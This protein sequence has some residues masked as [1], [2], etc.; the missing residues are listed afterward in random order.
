MCK[1]DFQKMVISQDALKCSYTLDRISTKSNYKKD[2]SYPYYKQLS[3]WNWYYLDSTTNEFISFD[4]P[5]SP[6]SLQSTRIEFFYSYCRKNNK[7]VFFH[8]EFGFNFK[9]MKFFSKTLSFDVAMR[10]RSHFR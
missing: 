7:I 1:I 5:N 6:Y 2:D 10:R 8:E 4:S 9:Y 3:K